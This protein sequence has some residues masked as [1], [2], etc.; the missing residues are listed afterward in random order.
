MNAPQRRPSPHFHPHGL[1][2]LWN[3]LESFGAGFLSL[4]QLL[5]LFEQHGRAFRAA[6]EQSGMGPICVPL[7][8][9][10]DWLYGTLPILREHDKQLP[11]KSFGAQIDRI[12]RIVRKPFKPPDLEN[13]IV[14]LARRLEDD[15]LQEKFYYVRRE[16]LHYFSD[17]QQFGETVEYRI[18]TAI[19][20]I[21]EAGKCL[22]LDRGTAAVFHL[23]RVMEASLKEL[24]KLLD[25]PYA[26]SWE[27][28]IKQINDK[29]TAKHNSKSPKWKKSEHFF[30]DVLGDLQSVKMAWRNPTMHIVRHYN[31]E[32]AEEIFIAARRFV[33]RVAEKLPISKIEKLIG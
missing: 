25:I 2:S 12:E 31:M 26:P 15:L 10:Q 20:D 6:F 17:K 19:S 30:R 4:T 9:K 24:A 3:M 7:D 22:A 33:I 13:A 27:S 18:P 32:E 23:M 1:W 5:I 8:E 29:I 16:K 28:Y 11:M 14:E 21:E